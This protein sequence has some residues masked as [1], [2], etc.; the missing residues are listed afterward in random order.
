MRRG[1]FI[2]GGT[3]IEKKNIADFS[4]HRMMCVPV[5]NTVHVTELI[6]KFLFQTLGS[7]PAVDQSNFKSANVHNQ[8]FGQFLFHP[9]AVHVAANRPHRLTPENI[10]NAQIHQIPGMQNQID[11]LEILLNN[12]F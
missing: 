2:H 12:A 8:M 1:S 3:G 5:Y 9:R 11:R 7:A 6:G 10:Q 4:I